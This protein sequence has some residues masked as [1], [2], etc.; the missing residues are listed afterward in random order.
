MTSMHP[1]WQATEDEDAVPVRVRTEAVTPVRVSR[2][3]AALIGV[4]LMIG[5]AAVWF[6]GVRELIGQLTNPTPDV[7]IKLTQDGPEPASATVKAGQVIRFLNEDQIPHVL[8]S[9]TLPTANGVPFA[10][11]GI[12]AG[13][14]YFYTVPASAPDGTYEYISETSPEFSGTI[15]LSSAPAAASASSIP[16]VTPVAAASS[17]PTAASAVPL[18]VAASSSSAAPS[19]LTAGVIAVNPY[20]VGKKSAGAPSSKKPGV[21]QHKPVKNAESGPEIWLAIGC[22][23]VAIAFAAKEAFRKA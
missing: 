14:D 19:P 2:A 17:V 16:A 18:P 22:G 21:A 3:P 9:K 5:F 23:A 20:V 6:G 4:L 1:H 10:S 12:F 7:T 13:S 11:P 8:S 15:V